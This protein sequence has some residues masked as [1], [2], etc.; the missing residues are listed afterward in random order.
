MAIAKAKEAKK[1]A[2]LL[3][4]DDEESI[5]MALKDTLSLQGYKVSTATSAEEA[6][7]VLKKGAIDL[8]IIDIKLPGMS[9]IELLGKAKEIDSEIMQLI[10]TSHAS[11]ETAVEALRHGAEDYI[12]KPFSMDDLKMSVE[13]ALE[14][15]GLQRENKKLTEE[16]KKRVQELEVA[17]AQLA[18]LH[19]TLSNLL[20]QMIQGVVAVDRD[21]NV[22]VFNKES[23]RLFGCAQKEALGKSLAHSSLSGV[24][25]F[26][27]D[28]LHLVEERERIVEH[29]KG[30]KI[31]EKV[32]PLSVSG[33][34]LK[35]KKGKP[36]GSFFVLRDLTETKKLMALEEIDRM[37]SEFVSQVSHELRTPLTSI[38]AYAETLLESVDAGDTETQREFLK[39][40]NS[41]SDRLTELIEDLLSLSR[42]EARDVRI[43]KVS[44]SLKEEI[45]RVLDVLKPRAQKNN[46][47]IVVKFDEDVPKITADRDMMAQLFVNLIGNAI[48]YSP[49]GGEITVSACF[50]EHVD[51]VDGDI[52]EKNNHAG[53]NTDV[54]EITVSDQGIGIPKDDIPYIFD[55][56]YRAHHEIVKQLSGTGLGLAIT[57]QIVVDLHHGEIFA[58]SKLDHGS[59]FTAR[60]PVGEDS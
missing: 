20:E 53:L 40:I 39:I 3:V 49:A 41:E 33:V 55:K 6:L 47:S 43:R 24:K 19:A 56:F 23:E 27:L 42:I 25:D 46:V 36:T 29:E 26:L 14:K 13:G 59:V 18:G 22:V 44:L 1:G 10:I 38:K 52:H 60:L 5:C 37:K 12:L 7:K 34:L 50:V 11:I 35:D 51:D 28:F 57:K 2:R 16:L 8:M 32:F 30:L 4:V 58:K 17:H 9:G 45:G 31:H 48:K 54:V 15:Q 21:A